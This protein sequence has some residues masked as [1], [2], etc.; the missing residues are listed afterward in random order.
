MEA[1]EVKRR[2]FTRQEDADIL[3][4]RS[5]GMSL[6]RIAAITGRDASVIANRL[7]I[8]AKDGKIYRREWQTRPGPV[9]G[10]IEVELTKGAIATI[11]AIDLPVVEPHLW[12]LRTDDHRLYAIRNIPRPGG[13]Q[14]TMAM[15]RFIMGTQDGGPIVDHWDGN[16]LN[17][18]RSNLRVTTQEYNIGNSRRRKDNKS[19]FKGVSAHEKRWVVNIGGRYHGIFDAVEEAARAYDEKARELW[20]EFAQVNLP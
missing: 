1:G 12:S 17:N 11:D 9:P 18:T 6:G 20:G 15:H 3:R 2:E 16:G 4:M 10:T 5:E 19:G 13:G 7:K 8:L 14:I